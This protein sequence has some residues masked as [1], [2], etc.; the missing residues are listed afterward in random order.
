M[1]SVPRR[2]LE[3]GAQFAARGEVV[4]AECVFLLIFGLFVGAK[5]SVFSWNEDIHAKQSVT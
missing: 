2:L 4:K 3:L 1:F 5:Y